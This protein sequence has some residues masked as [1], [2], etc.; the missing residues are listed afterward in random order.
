MAFGITTY[1]VAVGHNN[2]AGLSTITPQ[3]RNPS[4]I[5][6]PEFLVGLDGSMIP[7]GNQFAELLFAALSYSE[8]TGVLAKFGL[9][10]TVFSAACTVR[11]R[12]DGDLY[13]NYNGIASHTTGKQRGYGFWKDFTITVGWLEAI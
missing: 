11:L 8:Y 7:Q 12:T 3:P 9:S 5:Q 2:A 10:A 6:Y 1:K 13:Q 4:D